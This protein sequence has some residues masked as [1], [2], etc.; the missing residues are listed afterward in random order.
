MWQ[1]YKDNLDVL[2]VC[3]WADLQE[4][5]ESVNMRVLSQRMRGTSASKFHVRALQ[6]QALGDQF[7][8]FQ[9]VTGPPAA[10]FGNGCIFTLAT[11]S[12]SQVGRKWM[13]ILAGRWMR[14]FSIQA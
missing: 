6:T 5:T 10:L 7:G 9:G 1:V 2:D 12:L 13:Q 11:F 4:L 14:V 8:G 3:D